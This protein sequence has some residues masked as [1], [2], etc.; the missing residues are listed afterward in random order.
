MTSRAALSV[1]LLVVGVCCVLPSCDGAGTSEVLQ[2]PSAK[3][4]PMCQLGCQGTGDPNPGAPGVFL[5]EGARPID[6][7]DGVQNDLDEDGVGDYCEKRVAEAF[8]PQLAVGQ[9]DNV[10]REPRWALKLA[11]NF[12]NHQALAIFYALSYYVDLG[13]NDPICNNFFADEL[14]RGHYGDSEDLVFRVGFN[15]TTQHW[16][17][18]EALLSQHGAYQALEAGSGGYVD[19]LQYPVHQGAAPR[20]WV[21]YRKHANYPDVV[22]CDNGAF[23]HLDQCIAP[24]NYV[25]IGVEANG[26]LGSSSHPLIDC[27]SSNNPIYSGNGTECYWTADRFTGWQFTT[28]DCVGYRASLLAQGF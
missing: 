26:N 3:V 6:C 7:F 4:Q 25:P 13:T 1:M 19:A 16:V 11:Y 23:F 22:S 14:C 28:P 2:G 21:A 15:W 17:L 20:I 24:F 12:G 10:G 5:G 8:A 9:T 27:V 18:T